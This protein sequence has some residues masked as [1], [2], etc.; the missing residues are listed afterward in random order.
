[1]TMG[2]RPSLPRVP[3]HATQLDLLPPEKRT[4]TQR[5]VQCNSYLKGDGPTNGLATETDKAGVLAILDA[6][7][8]LAIG[9]GSVVPICPSAISHARVGSDRNSRL[10]AA[11]I[12]A[13]LSVGIPLMAALQMQ[14]DAI[15]M[16]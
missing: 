14:R 9:V 1:M 5:T 2:I 10:A 4:L 8:E 13:C 12:A 11:F 7:D 16:A 15:S 6:G 3:A